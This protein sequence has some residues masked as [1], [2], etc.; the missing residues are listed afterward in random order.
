[1]AFFR[2]S[3]EFSDKNPLLFHLMWEFPPGEER[4]RLKGTS[5]DIVNRLVIKVH[6]K[7]TITS[8]AIAL[9]IQIW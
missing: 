3:F 8:I 1:M 4:I 7:K 6:L 5:K 2:V 9:E